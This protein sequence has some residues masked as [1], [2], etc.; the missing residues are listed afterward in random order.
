MPLPCL[1]LRCLVNVRLYALENRSHWFVLLFRRFVRS[2]VSYGFLRGL[3][4]SVGRETIWSGVAPRRWVWSRSRASCWRKLLS[5]RTLRVARWS[6]GRDR[7]REAS[8]SSPATPEALARRGARPKRRCDEGWCWRVPMIRAREASRR[9]EGLWGQA[10][11]GRE[12][13]LPYCAPKPLA[14]DSFQLTSYKQRGAWCF[15]WFGLRV[16]S[17]QRSRRSSPISPRNTFASAAFKS[18][19]EAPVDQPRH[20]PFRAASAG[21][22]RSPSSRCVLGNSASASVQIAVSHRQRSHLEAP[23]GGSTDGV[24][25]GA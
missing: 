19:V 18:V 23:T 12:I 20:P 11:A 3:R 2:R 9:S 8:S 13:G 1:P 5:L 7:Y 17:I 21:R 24:S 15:S 4:C 6:Q 14:G 25:G 10:V 16:G 22:S